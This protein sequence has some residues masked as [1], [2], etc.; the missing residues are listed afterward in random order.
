LQL[1]TMLLNNWCGK[2][3]NKIKFIQDVQS[4]NSPNYPEY[5]KTLGLMSFS[6]V[7]FHQNI[8][9]DI[10]S[11]AQLLIDGQPRC[12]RTAEHCCFPVKVLYFCLD[13]AICATLPTF[14]LGS[15]LKK[16]QKFN[17]LWRK[18]IL[19]KIFNY[20]NNSSSV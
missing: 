18:I 15:W 2:Y 8:F 7:V 9:M 17:L 1:I 14:K 19:N 12:H 5:F 20:P 16:N 13:I 4:V 6:I 10:V 3:F 11:D